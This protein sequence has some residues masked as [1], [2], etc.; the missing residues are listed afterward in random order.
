MLDPS[1]LDFPDPARAPTH[2]PLA[3]GGDLSAERLVRAYELGIF[4]WYDVGTPPLWWSPDPRAILEPAAIHVSRS[5]RRTLRQRRF[6]LTWSQ[7]FDEVI[8]GCATVRRQGTWILPEMARAYSRLHALGHAH[9]VEVWRGDEL[10]GGLYG[11]LVGGLF[12]GE[13]MFSRDTDAS[14]VALVAGARALFAVGLRVFDVQFLTEHLA[15]LG[16]AEISRDDY[17][18]RARDARGATVALPRLDLA[19]ACD[20]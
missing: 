8:E 6:R 3:R 16:A 14:K 18:A 1:G 5:L 4:P 12:A 20:V 19:R 17:L 13:S 2:A 9:S 7:R 15:S 10:V 11:V